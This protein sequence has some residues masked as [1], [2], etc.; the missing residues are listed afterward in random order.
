VGLPDPR[1]PLRADHRYIQKLLS[2]VLGGKVED[3]PEEYDR[4]SKVFV[5]AGGS[6]AGIFHGSPL[7]VQKLKK[8]IKIAYDKGHLTKKYQWGRRKRDLGQSKSRQD[9]D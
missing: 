4:I 6:W 2:V 9:E 1:R 7:H 5:K 8:V 3:V